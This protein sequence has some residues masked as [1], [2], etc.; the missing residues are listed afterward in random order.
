M[1]KAKLMYS[2]FS[3]LVLCMFNT[4]VFANVITLDDIPLDYRYQNL[5]SYDEGGFNISASCTNC[6]NVFSTVEPNAGY[7]TSSGAAGWG[8][9]NRFLETWN[10]TVIFSLTAKSEIPF[11][12]L[13]F[14]IGWFDNDT[15]NASW[16]VRTYDEFGGL[17]DE[18]AYTGIGHFDTSY[19]G[20]YTV[21]FQ[22]NGGFSSIDNINASVPEPATY[23]ILGLSVL[24]LSSR[25]LFR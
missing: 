21:T 7:P 12:L 16:T 1:V 2:I 11:D 14:D 13:G 17:I 6:S 3:M 18:D 8:A 23:V 24:L 19:L 10:T 25:K 5:P 15:N 22:S 20:V 9:S 4:S